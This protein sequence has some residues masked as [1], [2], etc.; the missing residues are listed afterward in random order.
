[1]IICQPETLPDPA[2]EAVARWVRSNGSRLFGLVLRQNIGRFL[3]DQ[4]YERRRDF[5]GIEKLDILLDSGGGNVEAAYQ[6]I[7]FLRR[8]CKQ[9][10][11]I[12]PDWAKSAAT[13]FALGADEILMSETAELG[14]LDAQI[15]DPRDPH[16]SISA[17]DE[18]RAIEYLRSHGFE[19]FDQF[20]D[21]LRRATRLKVADIVS[22]GIDY[23]TRIMAPLY[24][25]VD[26]LYFGGAHRALDLSIEYGYRVMSRY[27]YKSWT[28]KKVRDVLKR[29][30]TVYPSHTFVID[31]TE[32]KELGLNVRLLTGE[33][34]DCAHTIYSALTECVGFLDETI[35]PGV[36]PAIPTDTGA[37]DVG[38]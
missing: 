27:S 19:I 14:P 16:N 4:I 33:L 25:Q 30:T 12:V 23:A 38:Q 8:K 32:A 15:P 34:E 26:P 1:M 2:R 29:L 6:L 20:H 9:V 18:F 36:A 22:H 28:D 3:V 5:D 13:L 24:A 7:T 10:R 21:V 17:L 11:V 35:I 37:A 31:Y